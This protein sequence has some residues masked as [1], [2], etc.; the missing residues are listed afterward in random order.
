MKVITFSEEAR[1]KLK[2]GVDLIANA[3]KVT[4]GPR[5]RNMIYG[6]PYGFPVSTKDGVTVAR[7]IEAK[8]PT[9]QLGVLLIR[10]VAQKTVDDVGDG[11]T[12][13]TL[14][15]QIIFKE[16]LKSLQSGANPVLIKK[17]IDNAV[18][19]V[20]DH[21][22]RVKIPIITDE[23]R[24]KVAGISANNNEDIGRLINEAIKKVGE[25]GVITLEDNYLGPE[26]YIDVLEGMQLNEGLQSPYFITDKE[27]MAAEYK[28][29]YL[30]IIDGEIEIISQVKGI[31]EK[32]LGTGRPVVLMANGYSN[33]VLQELVRSRIEQKLSL[34]VVKSSYF[35]EYRTE[36]LIDIATITGGKVIGSSTG[37][38]VEEAD[39][40]HLG[41]C[42]TIKAT[43]NYTTIIDG[44][45][46]QG[47][48]DARIAL[49]RKS[50]EESESDYE[51]EKF[52]ERLSKLTSGVAVIKVGA[53]TEVERKEKKMRVED[54]LLAT[55]AA[56]E[57]GVVAG[58]GLTLLKSINWIKEEGEEEELIG[59]RI[60]KKAL[61]A[62]IQTIAENSGAEGAE[63]I[64]KIL[65][66]QYL[67]NYGYN[68]MTGRYENLIESGVVDPVKVVKATLI[69]AAS[70][71]GILLTTE[72][73]C[74]DEEEEEIARTPRP[75]S[76]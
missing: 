22:D 52:R 76:V 70:V 38:R 40:V 64:A 3:V 45:G 30:I 57:E 34:L 7:Q 74:C 32:A 36:Q 8:D 1:K 60:I 25:D 42:G 19:E 20:I 16:G 12:T 49:L 21:I 61:R 4:L 62:P 13:A 56:I 23:D 14:L 66:S 24:I 9:E 73:A 55:R 50:I 31:L 27:K 47:D 75:R 18:S 29:A 41:R 37:L 63:I 6:F 67:E 53:P 15:A 51:K 2:N 44:F 48:I 28:N 65:S 39:I 54:A 26:T 68:F 43:R 10:Q 5:G 72:V 59:R 35:G 33:I 58:G 46:E 11:T 17:G 71:A 69:N